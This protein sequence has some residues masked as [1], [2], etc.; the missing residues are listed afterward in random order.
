MKH[1]ISNKTRKLGYGYKKW[2]DGEPNAPNFT[3]TIKSIREQIASDR[4]LQSLKES[5]IYYNWK[6]FYGDLPILDASPVGE[7]NSDTYLDMAK[8]FLIDSSKRVQIKTESSNRLT[9]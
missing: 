6:F 4:Y 9:N 5:N 3:G 1:I 7:W 2:S 8:E